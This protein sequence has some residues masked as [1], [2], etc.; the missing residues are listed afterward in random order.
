M[1]DTIRRQR[2]FGGGAEISC[3]RT[4]GRWA[5]KYAKK[6]VAWDNAPSKE[7]FDELFRVSEQQIIWGGNYF[8]LPPTRCF[9]IWDKQNISDT[10]SMAMCEYAWTSFN[11]N[12]KIFRMVPQNMNFGT[13]FHP[14]EKPMELYAWIYNLFAKPGYRI[15]D[16]HLGSGSSRLAAYDAGLDF[17][18]CEIDKEYFE[19]QEERFMDYTAQTNLF[20][21]G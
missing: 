8:G 11:E 3:T 21:G 6:I 4:G 15:L 2:R 16:T 9:L 1:T 17:V 10:F 20:I 14:T 13:R 5:A 18:G 7:Y 12:A 19:K